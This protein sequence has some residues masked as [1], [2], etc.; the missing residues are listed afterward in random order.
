MK[1]TKADHKL[2]RKLALK[3]QYEKQGMETMYCK[4]S[5][6][7]KKGITKNEKGVDINPERYYKL[8]HRP[9]NHVKRMKRLLRS[10]STNEVATQRIIQ[11]FGKHKIKAS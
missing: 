10:A 3:C 5:A 6:L 4:G 9:V 2:I 8:N 7:I 11:Y 1:V